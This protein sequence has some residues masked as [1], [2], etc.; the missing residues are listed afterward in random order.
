[1]SLKAMKNFGVNTDGLRLVVESAEN[2]ELDGREAFRMSYFT[3][4]EEKKLS[5]ILLYA[6]P[7]RMILLAGTLYAEDAACEEICSGVAESLRWE[8]P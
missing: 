8:E 3:G 2:M 1:M 7:D 6:I 4:T 5:R